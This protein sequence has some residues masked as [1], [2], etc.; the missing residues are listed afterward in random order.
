MG[1]EQITAVIPGIIPKTG[2]S[3]LHQ[4][5]AFEAAQF[6]LQKEGH[7]VVAIYFFCA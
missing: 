7:I 3:F 2:Q 6:K 1:F 4:T 5:I